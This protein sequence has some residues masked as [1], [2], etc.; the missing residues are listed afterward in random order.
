MS[1][2]TTEAGNA[3]SPAASARSF[4][5]GLGMKG[6]GLIFL[7]PYVLVF[8]A[9]VV[10][11]VLYGF[12]LGSRPEIYVQLFKDPA[13]W[14]AYT[15]TIIFLFV[16]VNLKFL[17]ALGISGFFVVQRRWIQ[18]MLVIFILP[19]AM[20]SIPT[21][22]SFRFMLNAEW[23]IINAEYF[24]W[25]FQDGPG[26]PG[27][28]NRPDLAFMWSIIVHI[29]KSLPFWTL[30]LITG[31]LAIPQDQYEAAAVDGA[32]PWQQFRFIT[33]PAL[34]T[35]YITSTL[36]SMIWTLGDFNSV[37]LLTGGGP[38]DKTHVLATLG[39]RYLRIDQLELG[40]AAIITA[41]PLIVPMVWFM[42]KRLSRG[43]GE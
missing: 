29:W 19:W 32:S 34:A 1:A 38:G 16:A 12:W 37:Y 27:W 8:A 35:L 15:N 21:I 18:V 36:L 28:L 26:G 41:M 42:V 7:I 5:D 14:T 17:L 4:S 22:L 2:V 39:V 25:T 6:W 13:F 23:G 31:R 24:R 20:P 33:W 43:P 30:I 9:F 10:Y 3:A 40:I 11:P